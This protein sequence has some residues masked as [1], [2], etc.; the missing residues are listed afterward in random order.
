MS[1]SVPSDF[2]LLSLFNVDWPHLERH[3]SDDLASVSHDVREEL[4]ACWCVVQMVC[5]RENGQERHL[6]PPLF[7]KLTS[8]TLVVGVEPLKRQ[9]GDVGK[10]GL[11]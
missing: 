8:V 4:D 10:V 1:L 6:V 3:Q 5:R 11:T 9:V 2:E 7:Q